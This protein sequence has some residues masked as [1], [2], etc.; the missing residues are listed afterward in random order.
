MHALQFDRFGPPSELHL[1][2][3]PDPHPG[4]DEVLIEVHAAALNPSDG[5]NV[6]GNM[7]Q[8][9]LPRIPGR[10]FAG[11]VRQGPA[12]LVGKAV[13]GTGAELGYT[14][15]GSHA[16]LLALP[17]NAVSLKPSK[18]SMREA[19]SVGVPYVTAWL[20]LVDAAQVASGETVVILGGTGAVGWAAT[21]LALWKGARVLSIVR[22]E[23]RAMLH[24]PPESLLSYIDMRRADP[25]EM[26]L[27]ETGGTGADIV[28]DT[29]GGV[30]F[31]QGLQFLK[32]RGRIIEITAP[33]DRRVSFDMRDFY[34]HEL[35]IFGVDSLHA[36]TSTSARILD[37][38]AAGFASGALT[39]LV[40]HTYPLADAVT[41]YEHLVQGQVHGKVVLTVAG[42]Q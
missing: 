25:R 33:R 2:D 16:E 36:T 7:P 20:G 29:V 13:W 21:Q 8:T 6:Q 24:N 18:L 31:E 30:F 35:R 39:T 1:R 26:I 17:A 27:H 32:Q 19:A 5:K 12:D 22:R 15:D 14:H 9:T 42:V 38:L 10:D 11:I 4:P 40:D 3:L 34:R 23:P 41:A 37:E 28:L